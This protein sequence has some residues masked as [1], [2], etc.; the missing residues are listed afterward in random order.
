MGRRLRSSSNIHAT[1]C[2]RVSPFNEVPRSLAVRAR[3]ALLPRMSRFEKDAHSRGWA[4]LLSLGSDTVIAAVIVTVFWTSDWPFS[5]TPER[6]LWASLSLVL[7]SMIILRWQAPTFSPL[8]VLAATVVGWLNGMSDDPLLAVAWCLYPLAL[9]RGLRTRLLGFIAL[10]TLPM[11]LVTAVPGSL[12]FIGQPLVVGAGAIGAVWILGHIEAQRQVANQ[13]VVREQ[14]AVERAREQNRMGREV[15]DVVGHSLCVISAEA[16]IARDMPN[17][18]L[19]DWQETLTSIELR[20]RGALEDMQSLVR[21]LRAGDTDPTT[22]HSRDLSELVTAARLSGLDVSARLD[23]PPA[24]VDVRTAVT[25]VA[26]E[27]LSNVIRHSGAMTCEV[28][29]RGDGDVVVVQVDD[30]GSGLP[31]RL[32]PGTGLVGMNER[33]EELAGALTVTT[34][35]EGGTRVLARIPTRTMP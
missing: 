7:V 3:V 12:L 33:V 10:A 32:Q 17:T 35:L 16:A 25:R 22:E 29:V 11:S 30:D 24:S 21:A 31:S 26:Q 9:R 6:M 20:A 27:A 14:V 28:S 23:P 5:G 18:S 13:Q 2:A 1:G 19:R 4:N 34:R 15:H 8:M